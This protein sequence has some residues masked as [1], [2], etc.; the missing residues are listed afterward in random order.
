MA[1]AS[2]ERGG[3]EAVQAILA[4]IKMAHQSPQ[5][6]REPELAEEALEAYRLMRQKALAYIGTDKAKSRGQVK[7]KLALKLPDQV[8]K[9][10]HLPDLV[11]DK[12]VEDRYLDEVLCGRRLIKR[13]SGRRQKSK[14]YI[15][16]LLYQQGISRPVIKEL[17]DSLE[18]D[19]TTAKDYFD[20]KKDQWDYSD[21]AKIARHFASRGYSPS[22]SYEIMRKYADGKEG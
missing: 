1:K 19:R 15:E 11:V 10:P 9:Y 17:L 21:P 3:L 22:I 8:E 6:A 20:L 12:L 7:Q 14:A 18:D 5:T 13:H 2:E 4:E 16:Q